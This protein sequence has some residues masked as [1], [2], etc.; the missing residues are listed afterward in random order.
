MDC[1]TVP[2]GAFQDV[3]SMRN[4]CEWTRF[5]GP[6]D[7][8]E[9]CWLVEIAELCG[10]FPKTT[11]SSLGETSFFLRSESKLTQETRAE[12]MGISCRYFQIIEAG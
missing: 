8:I 10:S 2:D 6:F 4:Q 9:L 1:K 3:C 11:S 7:R 5:R 12:N